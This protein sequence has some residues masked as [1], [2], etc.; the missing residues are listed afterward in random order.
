MDGSIDNTGDG[1]VVA[2]GD[3]IFDEYDPIS[4]EGWPLW[5]Q[6]G[7]DHA[8]AVLMISSPA[9]HRRVMRREAAG[10]GLGVQWEGNLIYNKR[11]GYT[12]HCHKYNAVRPMNVR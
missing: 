11:Y 5:M 1:P 9:Y 7:L 8:D 2:G 12:L 6:R 3:V 10:K 4:A